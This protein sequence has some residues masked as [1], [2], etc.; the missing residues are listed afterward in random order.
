MIVG[1]GG[2]WMIQLGLHEAADDVYIC[3]SIA[4]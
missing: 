1:D 4:R 3:L 2:Q